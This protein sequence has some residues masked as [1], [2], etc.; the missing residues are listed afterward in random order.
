[1][2]AL[3][4]PVHHVKFN[5]L[6][7]LLQSIP[8]SEVDRLD[9][10]IVL[11]VSNEKEKIQIYRAIQHLLPSHLRYIKFFDVQLYIEKVLLDELVLERYLKNTDRCIVNLKKFIGLFWAKDHYEYM[12]VIDCDTIFNKTT[13]NLF[14]NL[15]TNY[16]SKLFFSGGVNTPNAILNLQKESAN[17]FVTSDFKKLQEITGEFHRYSWFFDAPFYEK[18]HLNDFFDYFL[19]ERKDDFNFW[20]A[21]KWGTFEHLIYTFYLL[22]FK[23]YTMIDYGEKVRSIIPEVLTLSDL[24]QIEIV[25][26]YTPVWT[27]F[28]NTLS[29]PENVTLE[30]PSF[31]YHMDRI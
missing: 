26:Q 30:E 16:K 8:L 1:M 27:L 6:Y 21:I 11:L 24:N 17:L 7:M 22:L 19:I 31:Y 20:Y 23:G 9:F 2:N 3:I 4:I 15:I 28:K 29:N 5:W 12:C 13:K 18:N 14:K 25:Y 10:D